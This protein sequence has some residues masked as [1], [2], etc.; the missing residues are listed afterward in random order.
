MDNR[1]VLS[2]DKILNKRFTPNVKGYDSDEVDEFLDQVIQDYRTFANYVKESTNYIN[3]LELENRRVKDEKRKLEV[4]NGSMKN[5]LEG[6]KEGDHVTSESMDLLKRIDKMERAL[7]K[8]G[9]DPTK[10]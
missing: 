9:V 1:L 2:T 4:S 8:M 7:W 10:L 5:R 6:I 3:N